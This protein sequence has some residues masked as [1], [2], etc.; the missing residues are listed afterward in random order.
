[1]QIDYV[2]IKKA[3]RNPFRILRFI[4]T[5]VITFWYRLKYEKI[6]RRAHFGKGIRIHGKLIIKGPGSV[7]F[8]NGVVCAM[9]VTPF[10]HS[11]DAIIQIGDGTF[12]NGTRFGAAKLITIGARCILADCRI[13]DTDFHSLRKDRHSPDAPVEV[14]P[15]SI[16]NNV[17][18]CAQAAVLKGV[19]I[20]ENSVVGFGA[21]VTNNVESNAV[22]AGNP[23][24]AVK[25]IPQ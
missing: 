13:M 14:S 19:T 4:G 18:I 11:R 10:T 16:G 1:M 3:I 7:I 2:K 23:A 21:V 8:G 12:L 17:W 5:I 22:A 24:K 6:L 20:G 15:I 25:K 9:T